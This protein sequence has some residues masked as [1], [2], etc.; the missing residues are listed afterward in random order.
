[1]KNKMIAYTTR[2]L[3]I[4]QT[5]L[6][7][8]AE[9]GIQE[10]TTKLLAARIGFSEAAIYRHFKS[11][12]EILEAVLGYFG[13]AKEKK[14]YE[15]IAS[16][17]NPFAKMEAVLR[18]HFEMFTLQ[19]ALA[20]VIF[21]EASFQND[22]ILAQKTISLMVNTQRDFL[23]IIFSANELHLLRED[24]PPEHLVLIIM[25][26]MRLIVNKW[27]LSKQNFDLIREG[28][29]LWVSLKKIITE[30]NHAE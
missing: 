18:F 19:P 11:K 26:S 30:Q 14:I 8:I 1:M 21:S 24:I 4:I 2:Q 9:S 27:H 15:I 22:K 13:N 20:A 23:K 3:E 7:I 28:N 10:L 5:A 29:R 16:N 6:E 17:S 12:L 25:G